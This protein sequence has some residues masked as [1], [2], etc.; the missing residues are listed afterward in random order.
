MSGIDVWTDV[1][2]LVARG[3]TAARLARDLDALDEAER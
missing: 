2:G 1:L 3:Q